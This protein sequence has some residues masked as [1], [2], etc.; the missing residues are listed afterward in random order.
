MQ[1]R[2]KVAKKLEFEESSLSPSFL[3]QDSSTV[4]KLPEC[5]INPQRS[6][7]TKKVTNEQS[8]FGLRTPEPFHRNKSHLR[9]ENFSSD[10]F[11]SLHR[12]MLLE[13]LM[14]PSIETF[15]TE[16]IASKLQQLTIIPDRLTSLVNSL[17][18][19]TQSKA[20]NEQIIDILR[21]NNQEKQNTINYLKNCLERERTD[22]K[23][24]NN[25]IISSK[26]QEKLQ[27]RD[28]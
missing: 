2:R 20:Y 9:G 28:I 1:L 21:T 16:E 25:I 13:I 6:L 11:L 26:N 19:G 27:V 18:P 10:R 23:D 7:S 24:L 8:R 4:K 15:I 17:K 12:Q 5:K 22:K 3:K 14:L